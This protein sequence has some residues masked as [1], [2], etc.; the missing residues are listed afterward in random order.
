MKKNKKE[1]VI[2]GIL[3]AM[4]IAT[5]LIYAWGIHSSLSSGVPRGVEV[6]KGA[7]PVSGAAGSGAAGNEDDEPDITLLTD[8]LLNNVAYDC[9]LEQVD[10]GVTFPNKLKSGSYIEMYM[11]D[12]THADLLIVIKSTD[13]ASADA[14]RKSVES[15][16]EDS[17][18][19]YRDYIPEEAQK[20]SNAIVSQ[21]GQYVVA[22]VTADTDTAKN[23]IKEAFK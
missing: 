23:L 7:N 14:D 10:A 15:Y 5:A 9:K 3:S 8:N 1:T 17:R 20:V 12:G 16:L 22:C 6:N 4:L 2:H 13:K 18:D 19:S 21:S 11:G